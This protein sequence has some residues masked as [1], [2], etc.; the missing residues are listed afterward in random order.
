MTTAASLRISLCVG[1][2]VASIELRNSGG[3]SKSKSG[4]CSEHFDIVSQLE[5]IFASLGSKPII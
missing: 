2:L 4:I 5:Y 3:Y 1:K